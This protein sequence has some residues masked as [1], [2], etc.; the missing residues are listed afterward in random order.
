MAHKL[1]I[2]GK[3]KFDPTTHTYTRTDRDIKLKSVTT[4]LKE[5]TPPFIAENEAPRIAI[6][7]GTTTEVVLKEWDKKRVDSIETDN[8]IHNLLEN[9]MLGNT[10]KGKLQY[11]KKI[12]SAV[13]FYKDFITSG[14]LTPTDVETIVYNDHYADQID[15]VAK[16]KKGEHYILDYKTNEDIL[17][18]PN[19]KLLYPY[20]FLDNNKMNIYMLQLNSYA[21]LFEKNRNIRIKGAYIINITDEGYTIYSVSLEYK[22]QSLFK[23]FIESK[24]LDN[25]L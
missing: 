17:K 5:I 22:Q 10:V 3:V 4:K 21:Y 8:F 14:R 1:S 9:M 11:K 18:K 6:R 16:N 2:C 23:D 25:L 15:L 7:R 12:L 13:Q 24:E 20:N 19:G